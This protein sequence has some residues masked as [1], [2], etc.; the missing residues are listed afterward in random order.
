MVDTVDRKPRGKAWSVRDGHVSMTDA[1]HSKSRFMYSGALTCTGALLEPLSAQKSARGPLS[2][3]GDARLA[4]RA[5]AQPP[6]AVSHPA[7]LTHTGTWA[8]R[9]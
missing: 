5:T 4:R 8:R 7:R 2:A 6:R 9:T 1:I 3:A